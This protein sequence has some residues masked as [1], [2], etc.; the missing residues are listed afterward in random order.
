MTTACR[1]PKIIVTNHEAEYWT[2]AASLIHTDVDGLFDAEP[3]ENVRMYMVNG[4]QHSNTNAT[5]RSRPNW[6]H[7]GTTVDP[8]P[9]GRALLKALDRWVSQ[10]IEPPPSAV[11]RIDRG[12]LISVEQHQRFFP[13]IPGARHPGTLLQPPRVDYGDRFWTEGIQDN[14]PPKYFGPPYR[15][16][17]PNYDPD[18]NGIGGIRLPDLTVPLGTYQGFNPR[19]EEIG[20]PN[21]LSR[22]DGSFW[23]FPLT[24]KERVEK[25]DPRLS[26][27]AR[28]P[29]KEAYV[30]QV[31][32][33]TR[34]LEKQGFLL[35]EDADL[36]IERAKKM[37]WPPV[38][39][40]EYPYWKLEK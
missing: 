38:P 26:I 34:K 7:S 15:T 37:V 8:R 19:K 27:Q 25:G 30:E 28:Y 12:E 13:S 32:A 16:L 10:G 20:A 29:S 14:V 4:A 3:H 21:Y 9:V 2:R 31:T 33:E 11:P 35:K 6:E 39:I 36:I 1:F 23:M 40:D 17:V 24:E 5:T 22:F 18:G